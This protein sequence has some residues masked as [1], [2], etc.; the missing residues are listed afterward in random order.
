MAIRNPEADFPHETTVQISAINFAYG[1]VYFL[2]GLDE[3]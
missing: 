1:T 3:P 2:D